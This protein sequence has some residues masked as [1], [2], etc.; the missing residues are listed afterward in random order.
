MIETTFTSPKPPVHQE[1]CGEVSSSLVIN[2][3]ISIPP[4]IPTGNLDLKIDQSSEKGS[5][6]PEDS[7][8][9]PEKSPL[10]S[11]C[12]LKLSDCFSKSEADPKTVMSD[13][14]ES[15][16]SE[17]MNITAH[18][19]NEF[20]FNEKESD[21]SSEDAEEP[22]MTLPLPRLQRRSVP[23]KKLIE[24]NT[25]AD[26]WHPASGEDSNKSLDKP[27]DPP[28]QSTSKPLKSVL[29]KNSSSESESFDKH[30][31]RK[32]VSFNFPNGDVIF[33]EDVV[34]KDSAICNLDTESGQN[35]SLNGKK[36]S[37]TKNETNDEDVPSSHHSLNH[38]PSR[39]GSLQ[40]FY[41]VNRMK[42]SG[43]AHGD[44]DKSG[45]L[46]SG[47]SQG[48][49]GMGKETFSE[50]S[51]EIA[52]YSSEDSS[53]ENSCELEDKKF[54]MK[55]AKLKGYMDMAK[56]TYLQKLLRGV[57]DCCLDLDVRSLECESHTYT[58]GSNQAEDEAEDE[59]QNGDDKNDEEWED[60]EDELTEERY[61]ESGVEEEDE[62]DMPESEPYVERSENDEWYEECKEESGLDLQDNDEEVGS[63]E[64]S[65]G[66]Y[67]EDEFDSEDEKLA[68]LD[69]DQDEDMN[70][71]EEEDEE[72]DQGSSVSSERFLC[73]G[74]TSASGTRSGS[75]E[76]KPLQ[77]Y[78]SAS[79]ARVNEN[80]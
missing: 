42:L 70:F 5:Q 22:E 19:E 49:G 45:L 63:K 64:K 8:E 58:Q 67:E 25:W 59:K 29:K 47:L 24:V 68:A 36:E 76:L 30:D 11:P 75:S 56:N 35:N 41:L 51:E 77:L 74:R 54:V 27:S 28:S 20:Q 72:E 38:Y 16:K 6:R 26:I 12:V 3:E 44:E 50:S 31:G 18:I 43:Q 23:K 46:Q 34:S 21:E 37:D 73:T 10:L 80:I 69:T 14:K 1:P 7:L 48:D 32:S 2:T 13:T 52:S 15:K 62:T 57:E 65:E 61:I 78:Y 17:H 4:T 40:Q 9:S 53:E 79:L 66:T 60:E 33:K 39:R 55:L 71:K